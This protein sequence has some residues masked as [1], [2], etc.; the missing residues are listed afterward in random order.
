[1]CR[2]AFHEVFVREAS[3][4]SASDFEGVALNRFVNEWVDIPI[5]GADDDLPE[6]WGDTEESRLTN[7]DADQNADEAEDESDDVSA[8]VLPSPQEDTT[9]LIK[10]SDCR[11]DLERLTWLEDLAAMRAS[12][13]AAD[14]S[15]Q[16][17]PEPPKEAQFTAFM[18]ALA[19]DSTAD[20]S[21]NTS[22]PFGLY[23]GM[24]VSEVLDIGGMPLVGNED[25]FVLHPRDPDELL[26]SYVVA[27]YSGG[28][29]AIR[30]FG[31]ESRTNDRGEALRYQFH[32]LDVQLQ[33]KYG[34]RR[35][36]DALRPR[37]F[38][39]KSEDQGDAL[40]KQERI[41]HAV[42]KT[43]HGSTMPASIQV[44]TLTASMLRYGWGVLALGYDFINYSEF[45]DEV[46][47]LEYDDL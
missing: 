16:A 6:S 29:A 3:F 45:K 26:S 24:P 40:R 5:S 11:G 20:L 43:E 37:S 23:M 4:E 35:L 46:A 15:E 14:C 38:H 19:N 12:D 21:G 47:G 18:N 39:E 1:M 2:E 13:P 22:H 28:V 10:G 17:T 41:L 36:A 42:W 31:A 25:W 44:I 8:D 7:D 9:R 32:Q 34:D 33:L 30:A 27:I